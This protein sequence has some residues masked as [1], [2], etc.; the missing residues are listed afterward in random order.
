MW[1]L[2]AILETKL[3]SVQPFPV[4]AAVP[5]AANLQKFFFKKERDTNKVDH[6]IKVFK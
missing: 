1:Q 2:V 6:G 5:R 3:S 4:V